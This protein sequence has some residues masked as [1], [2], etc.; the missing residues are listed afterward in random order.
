[1]PARLPP[2]WYLAADAAQ[3]VAPLPGAGRSRPRHRSCRPRL[4]PRQMVF[5]REEALILELRRTRRL[6]I[7]R[8]RNALIREHVDLPRFRGRVSVWV[9]DA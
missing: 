9:Y 5:A 3:V 7:K 1:M 8:L 2:L 4:S 6:G